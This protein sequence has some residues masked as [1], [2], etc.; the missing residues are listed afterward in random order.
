MGDMRAD[1]NREGNHYRNRAPRTGH[2]RCA[3]ETD[4]DMR[5]FDRRLH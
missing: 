5:L 1:V 3:A 4:R 2:A